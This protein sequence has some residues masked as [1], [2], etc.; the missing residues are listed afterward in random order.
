MYKTKQ[1]AHVMIMNHVSPVKIQIS[2]QKLHYMDKQLNAIWEHID[3]KS[4]H[5]IECLS[6][7][8]SKSNCGRSVVY[9][10]YSSCGIYFMC[11]DIHPFPILIFI[12]KVSKTLLLLSDDTV[13]CCLGNLCV[14]FIVWIW[15]MPI[16][17]WLFSQDLLL[18]F[19]EGN[20]SMFMGRLMVIL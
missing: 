6:I 18:F 10:T 4:I 20:E 1:Y 16:I 11:L 15:L 8:I 12:G 17:K 9:Y 2:V 3:I 5:I 14:V 7:T 19:V 13:W